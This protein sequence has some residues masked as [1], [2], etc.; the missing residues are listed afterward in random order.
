MYFG[1][2]S[3]YQPGISRVNQFGS[4]LVELSGKANRRG[5]SRQF[6]FCSDAL[7]GSDGSF[8]EPAYITQQAEKEFGECDA[9]HRQPF[10]LATEWHK[11]T[12]HIARAAPNST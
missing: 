11:S 12:R 5:K 3:G 1:S 10:M 2:F 6:S 9:T 7:I 8:L 4:Q